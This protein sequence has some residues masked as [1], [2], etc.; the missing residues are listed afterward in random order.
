MPQFSSLVNGRAG[1]EPRRL[2]PGVWAVGTTKV[3]CSSEARRLSASLS[4]TSSELSRGAPPELGHCTHHFS[5]QLIPTGRARDFNTIHSVEKE[6]SEWQHVHYWLV[7]QNGVCL[8]RPSPIIYLLYHSY[9]NLSPADEDH[10]QYTWIYSHF[11]P[12]ENLAQLPPQGCISP[13]SAQCCS[14][15]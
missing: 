9:L 12:Q 8:H 4:R 15:L 2:N 11:S 13:A 6:S 5:V 1:F 10:E 7:A 14:S 3:P